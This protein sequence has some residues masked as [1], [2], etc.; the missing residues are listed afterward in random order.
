MTEVSRNQMDQMLDLAA[1]HDAELLPELAEWV[2]EGEWG[3]MLRHPLVYSIPL[4]LPGQANKSFLRKQELIQQA[5]EEED[6]H[7]LVFLHERPYR[8]TALLS[9]I[10][11]DEYGEPIPLV[12]T[13]E[14][15][16]LAA[17]VWV[18]SENIDQNIETW[19]A[20]FCNGEGGLWLGEPE[21]REEFDALPR[22]V[23]KDRDGKEREHIQ[24]WRGGSVG[25]WSWTTDRKIAEFFSR[26][27]GCAV[28]GYR[29]PVSD[30]FGYL[31]R[32]REAELM[33]KYTEFRAPLVY[34]DGAP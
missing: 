16:A 24:A 10:G 11:T 31:T 28:R 23:F 1:D 14:H 20:L 33:V 21:E 30:V 6:W 5:I 7:T 8:L 3:P 32:R 27:S 29:I 15:W 2:E 19:R 22:M 18:D 13:P 25:D 26:R 12:S 17:D 9:V 34:P 4:F